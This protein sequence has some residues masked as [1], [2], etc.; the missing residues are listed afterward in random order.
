MLKAPLMFIYLFQT[1]RIESLSLKENVDVAIL[2]T[3]QLSD[4]DEIITR[5]RASLRPPDGGLLQI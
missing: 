2:I 1:P 4:L 5:L 3:A